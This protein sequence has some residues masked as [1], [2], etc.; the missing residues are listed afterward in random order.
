MGTG[1]V[2]HARGVVGTGEVSHA[3]GVWG[4]VR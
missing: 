1:E 2:S 3:R 4:Q